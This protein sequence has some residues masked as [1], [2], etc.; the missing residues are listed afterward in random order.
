MF[1]IFLLFFKRPD[2][3]EARSNPSSL[4]QLDNTSLCLH[5]KPKTSNQVSFLHRL[6]DAHGKYLLLSD[7]S[8]KFA[9]FDS[10]LDKLRLPITYQPPLPSAITGIQSV[11]QSQR[12][13]VLPLIEKYFEW[14]GIFEDG[15]SN[16]VTKRSS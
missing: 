14:V 10:Q 2:L 13:E 15:V 16:L 6:Q 9:L 11:Q 3:Q 1:P 8:P 4:S 7:C 5:L 12:E